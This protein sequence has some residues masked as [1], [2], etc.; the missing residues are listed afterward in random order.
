MPIEYKRIACLHTMEQNPSAN[1]DDA[2][3]PNAVIMGQPV[4]SNDANTRLLP[5]GEEVHEERQTDYMLYGIAA[6]VLLVG[7]LL[8]F[9]PSHV[10]P[11]TSTTFT[12]HGVDDLTKFTDTYKAEDLDTHANYVMSNFNKI[13][14]LHPV[15]SHKY[16][17]GCYGPKI[18]V[19]DPS[20]F[21][22]QTQ[23]EL[24]LLQMQQNS[25]SSISVCTCI[26]A[27]VDI[28]FGATVFQSVDV[29]GFVPAKLSVLVE[30]YMN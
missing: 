17:V 27:H 21:W 15:G 5:Q 3:N 7:I 20:K 1:E 30:G 4:P 13:N 9:K 29:G 25:L 28:A 10:L 16:S 2:Y 12:M 11:R 19:L 18:P 23:S 8:A 26:D 6:A 14:H 22:F 24:T